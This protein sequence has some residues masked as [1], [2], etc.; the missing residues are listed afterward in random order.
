MLEK[1]YS[2]HLEYARSQIYNEIFDYVKCYRSCYRREDRVFDIALK[3][4]V[5]DLTY[6]E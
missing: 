4:M 6:I 2:A 5:F 3:I 1:E